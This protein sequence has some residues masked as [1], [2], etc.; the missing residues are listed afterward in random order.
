MAV[1]VL[2]MRRWRWVLAALA[3][4]AAAGATACFSPHQPGCAFSCTI[5][6]HACPADYTCGSD[7]LCHRADGTGICDVDAGD[8]TGNPADAAASTDADPD[9]I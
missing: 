1:A 3:V 6:P 5:P 4:L 7:G 2:M 8:Q 9:A